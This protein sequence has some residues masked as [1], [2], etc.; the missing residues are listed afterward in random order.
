MTKTVLDPTSERTPA[1]RERVARP[2]TLS[3]LKVGLLDIS[4]ARG[5][6][7]LDRLEELLSARGVTVSRF[8]KPTFTKPA[9]IDLRHEISTTCDV[10]IEALAD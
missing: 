7:F 9:P 5:N 3:G 1:H 8:A 2:A 10:V 6:V 4:K